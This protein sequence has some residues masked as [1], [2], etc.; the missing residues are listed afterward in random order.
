MQT[1]VLTISRSYEV[2]QQYPMN[3][4]DILFQSARLLFE[5]TSRGKP[6]I[7]MSLTSLSFAGLSVYISKKLEHLRMPGGCFDSDTTSMQMAREAGSTSADRQQSFALYHSSTSSS[8]YTLRG[9]GGGGGV[10][11]VEMLVVDNNS[12]DARNENLRSSW[13]RYHFNYL[14]F[15]NKSFRHSCLIFHYHVVTN[16]SN[17][18]SI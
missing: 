17:M 7:F 2:R 9:G 12:R 18:F 5:V 11:D 6:Q 13:T 14:D 8:R 3:C 1:R 10:D 4:L 15:K 16:V